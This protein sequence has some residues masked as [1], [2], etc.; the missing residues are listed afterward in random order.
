MKPVLLFATGAAA[1]IAL[2]VW[3]TQYGAEVWHT[4]AGSQADAPSR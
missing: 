2:I 4:T 3:R 1:A